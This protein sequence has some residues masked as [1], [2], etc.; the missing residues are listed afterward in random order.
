MPAGAVVVVVTVFSGVV[1][2]MKLVT[3]L[4]GAKTVL[5]KVAPS[6]IDVTV[7]TI[8]VE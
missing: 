4:G 6:I 7:V 3:V 1:E 5:I 2:Q 8:T